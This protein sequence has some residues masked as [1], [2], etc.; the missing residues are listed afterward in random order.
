MMMTSREY[1][2]DLA[3]RLAHIPAVYRVDGGDV[4]KLRDLAHLV[5]RTEQDV[6]IELVR[7]LIAQGYR[8]SVD[9]GG[10]S[11]EIEDSID[12]DAVTA[13]MFATDDEV[14]LVQKPNDRLSMIR[15]VYGNSPE[16]VIADYTARDD[17]TSIV[18]RVTHGL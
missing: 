15:L 13:E 18:Q 12:L 7:E 10:D 2:L 6:C 3:E 16:E 5:P 9:N 8:I 17:I 11:Y 4:D 1:L 14:L